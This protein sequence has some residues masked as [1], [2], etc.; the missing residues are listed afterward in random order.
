MIDNYGYEQKMIK[1]KQL[2]PLTVVVFLLL[3]MIFFNIS[4]SKTSDEKNIFLQ[5][6]S[7]GAATAYI[8]ALEGG[9]KFKGVIPIGGY[10]P[11]EAGIIDKLVNSNDLNFYVIHG[12]NDAKVKAAIAQEKTL[13]PYG[14]KMKFATLPN[15]S[16]S[17]YPLEEQENI[18]KWMN[19]L[20][21]H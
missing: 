9:I 15:F 16:T 3:F 19:G 11:L 20:I 21:W 14:A 12:S 6:Y 8:V 7:T 17:E 13:L 1:L 5:G 2:K 10:L 18:A 4:C